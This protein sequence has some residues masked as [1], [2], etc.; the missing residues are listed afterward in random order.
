MAGGAH[1]VGQAGGMPEPAAGAPGEADDNT[2]LAIY[3]RELADGVD[4]AL[5]RWVTR[6]VERVLQAQG[7][8]LSGETREQAVAAGEAACAEV[9]PRLRRLLE[10]DIDAQR[11]NPLA[12][13][14][15]A[16]T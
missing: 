11:T 7:R 3:A 1:P 2:R 16:V 9:M 5:A 10:A 15:G 12:I 13:I 14:R 6:S 8:Q 4:A